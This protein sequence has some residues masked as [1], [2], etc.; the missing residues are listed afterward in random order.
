MKAYHA[1]D[2]NGNLSLQSHQLETEDKDEEKINL[3]IRVKYEDNYE[4][5]KEINE[6]G[7]HFEFN[8]AQNHGKVISVEI[9]I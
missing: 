3:F 6:Y 7:H 8:D 9:D 4:Y 2:F 5:I 1:E